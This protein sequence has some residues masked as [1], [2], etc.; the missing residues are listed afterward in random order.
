MSKVGLNVGPISDALRR[1]GFP[2]QPVGAAYLRWPGPEPR[3]AAVPD[4]TFGVLAFA[5]QTLQMESSGGWVERRT[6]L[7]IYVTTTNGMTEITGKDKG[8]LLRGLFRGVIR[9]APE[10]TDAKVAILKSQEVEITQKL[11]RPT[12]NEFVAQIRHAVTP[13]FAGIIT[14]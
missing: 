13:L 3:P 9:K 12:E 2:Q 8:Q 10:A 6:S 14:D 5:R 1:F 11:R 4:E 7:Y